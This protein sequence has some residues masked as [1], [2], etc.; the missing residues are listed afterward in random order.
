MPGLPPDYVDAAY[1]VTAWE[2]VAQRKVRTLVRSGDC[3]TAANLL[4]WRLDGV[5]L[6]DERGA[7][8]SFKRATEALP[9]A[10]SWERKQFE[11]VT[12]LPAQTSA[13]KLATFVRSFRDDEYVD[14]LVLQQLTGLF[15][16][17]PEKMLALAAH[18][19]TKDPT[20]QSLG[21][22]GEMIAMV[23]R[24]KGPLTNA[25]MTFIQASDARRP[26]NAPA[27]HGFEHLL[28]NDEAFE[29][30][31]HM[32]TRF[33]GQRIRIGR[34]GVRHAGR[35]RTM[36]MTMH[37]GL[38]VYLSG[39][40]EALQSFIDAYTH[41]VHMIGALASNP[42]LLPVFLSRNMNIPGRLWRAT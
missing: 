5:M 20:W 7:S 8:E 6:G 21:M 30:S 33:V 29:L 12:N 15:S 13:E 1:A 27:R 2:P 42:I 4:A 41:D 37:S 3:P 25:A 9:R 18:A 16:V 22:L 32:G 36:H 40:N 23:N 39:N 31:A 28:E 26:M 14:P 38:A 10:A 24:R 34:D 11:I 35:W 17:E 19:A